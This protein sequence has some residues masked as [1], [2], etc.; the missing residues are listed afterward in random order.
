LRNNSASGTAHRQW[1]ATVDSPDRLL[2]SDSRYLYAHR[3]SNL[4]Y[5]E[6]ECVSR[7]EC[8]KS[9]ELTIRLAQE[10]NGSQRVAPIATAPLT[11]DEP[12][13]ALPEPRFVALQAGERIY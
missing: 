7:T 6:R 3:S 13:E 1:C 4:F 8:L 10:A 12:W 2:L 11:A 9:E 5:V